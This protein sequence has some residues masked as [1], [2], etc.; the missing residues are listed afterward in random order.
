MIEFAGDWTP[1][2]EMT[3]RVFLGIIEPKRK[4]ALPRV[5][6]LF[7]ATYRGWGGCLMSHDLDQLLYG[8]LREEQQPSARRQ[9]EPLWL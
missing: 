4:W 8:I 6:S 3:A 7:L 5:Q 9:Q 1:E 2:E